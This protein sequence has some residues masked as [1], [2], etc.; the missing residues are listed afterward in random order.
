MHNF[1]ILNQLVNK[2]SFVKFSV[3]VYVFYIFISSD[4]DLDYEIRKVFLADLK[5]HVDKYD[6]WLNIN[7]IL[8][9]LSLIHAL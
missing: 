2:K 4:E 8:S 9:T 7:M 5:E 1:L 3:H 6:C